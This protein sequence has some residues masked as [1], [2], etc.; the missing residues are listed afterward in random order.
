[1]PDWDDGASRRRDSHYNQQRSSFP[2]SEHDK[3][4]PSHPQSRHRS[5]PQ[6]AH[7]VDVVDDYTLQDIGEI[8]YALPSDPPSEPASPSPAPIVPRIPTRKGSMD[9][10]MPPTTALPPQADDRSI[11]GRSAYSIVLTELYVVS[12]LVF[13]SIL[14]TLA[15]LGLQW[16]T[17]YPGA[18]ITFSEFWANVAGTLFIGFLAE[19]RR[20]FRAEWGDS[21]YTPPSTPRP[22][23]TPQH[24]EEKDHESSNQ[25]AQ[26]SHMKVKKTIPL[27]IGLVTAFCGSFTS[28]SSFI[29][30]TFLAFVNDLPAPVNHTNTSINS[31]ATLPRNDGYSFM[32]G[33]AVII[34]TLGLCYAA[35]KVG[36]HLA[37]LLDPITPTLPFRLT[38]RIIDPIVVFLAWSSWLGA[39]FMAIWPPDRP[40]GP[41]SRGPWSNETWRGQAIFAC[42]FAPLGCLLRFYISLFLNPLIPSFPLGTF[43]VNIFGTAVLGMAYDLQHV[44]IGDFGA[45]GGRVGCQ[46]LQAVMDGF[47]G[48]LTTV[49]TWILEITSLKRRH[50][51]VYG[52]MSVWVGV[53]I[54]VIIMG[55]VKWTVGWV[56]VACVH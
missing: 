28:F 31:N 15:R 34:L 22:P 41:S 46:V 35:L 36:A 54:L 14:G 51:Y 4:A 24:D 55:S 25:A 13:F 38:R 43:V 16:L 37:I 48:T 32:A 2:R 56:A 53:L 26:A 5:A 23:R 19:D 7:M 45:G 27:Y 10:N 1:M 50:A 11:P 30:D 21:P 39:V 42:V 20:L 49:S 3:S 40:Y 52:A 29:R 8:S 9:R 17:F 6:G 33:L 18:P 12:H 47:C 44:A